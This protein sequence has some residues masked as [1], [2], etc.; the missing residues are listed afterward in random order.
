MK[1]NVAPFQSHPVFEPAQSCS[2]L[3]IGY[4]TSHSANPIGH[5]VTNLVKAL[6]LPNVKVCEVDRLTPK[7]AK[8]LATVDCAIFVD[9]CKMENTDLSV[10]PIN[11]RGLE[12]PGSSVPG[13]G[14]SW[15]PCSVLALIH[16]LYGHH[17]KSWWVKISSQVPISKQNPSHQVD[18][19]IRSAVREIKEL[20][21]SFAKE[22][23][24]QS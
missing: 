20:L 4:D 2:S 6:N 13:W 14:H 24:I 8:K 21:K 16:S 19:T 12:T 3:V 15:H 5:K 17:P 10:S 18:Q 23:Q 22:S 11:A 1:T 9:T 7:V